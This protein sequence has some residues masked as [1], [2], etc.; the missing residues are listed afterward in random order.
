LYLHGSAGAN[1]K[2]P[3]LNDLYFQ[4][5][6]NA[7]LKPENSLNS[8][9]GLHYKDNFNKV[10]IGG[11]VTLYSSDVKDWIIWLPTFKGYWQPENI[12]E[13]EVKGVESSLDLSGHAGEFHYLVKGSYALTRSLNMQRSE[14]PDDNSFGRQLPF[15]PV[16]SG[17]LM[18]DLDYR[19]WGFI[20][21]WNY[22]S[23]RYTTT[24]NFG[25]SG[26]DYLYPFF[27]N[28]VGLSRKFNMKNHA[29]DM[30]LK[31]FNL[32]NEKYRSVLQ[33]PMPGRNFS[34]QIKVDL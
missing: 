10:T 23:R 5:G 3:S 29:F 13:V 2:Y 21:I 7:S 9:L 25:S 12:G 32:F 16:H 18:T 22:Y 6:G 31:I 14:N 27:M 8:E 30:N 15:I 33:R 17:N 34:F 19:K 11:G 4:P 26:N 1:S 28:Q 24:S 20:Y